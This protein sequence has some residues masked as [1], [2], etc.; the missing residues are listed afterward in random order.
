MS[1]FFAYLAR[2]K[3]IRR[4]GLMHNTYP[5]NIQEH[6]LRVAIIAHALAVIRN[7]LF[8]GRVNPER[9]AAL[10]LFH[11]ASEVLTGDLPTPV[12]Y[13]NPDIRLAY[14][15]IES[16][17]KQKLIEMI[18][19][20]LQPDY[21]PLFFEDDVDREHQQ[22]VKAADRLAAY[23]KCLEELAAGN[24]EFS[25]AEKTLRQSVEASNLAEVKY[26]LD[27][28]VPSFRLTLDELG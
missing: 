14:Q 13:F 5:E 20:E 18:P 22:L 24:H 10:A 8:H 6:S 3:F 25:K 19:G 17:A 7:R 21:R 15:T 23:L 28:F 12:K 2:M 1:H 16:V 26:F 4:W 27:T 9:A 11:D